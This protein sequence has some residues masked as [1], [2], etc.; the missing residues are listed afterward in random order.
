MPPVSKKQARFLWARHP[1][2]MKRWEREGKARVEPKRK[3][4]GRG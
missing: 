3:H 1:E 4:K 2:I